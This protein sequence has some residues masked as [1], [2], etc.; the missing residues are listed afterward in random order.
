MQHIQSMDVLWCV[1]DYNHKIMW[2]STNDD[3][4]YR[5][6]RR[7]W[8]EMNLVWIV[9]AYAGVLFGWLT[10]RFARA[11]KK[12]SHLDIPVYFGIPFLIWAYARKMTH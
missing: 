2:M 11:L 9:G 4:L 1:N 3:T 10:L 12:S 6:K 5:Y 7:L 8:I